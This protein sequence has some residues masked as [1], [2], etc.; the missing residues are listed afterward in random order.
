MGH[1]KKTT[2]KE[3]QDIVRVKENSGNF[4][5]FELRSKNKKKG[6]D[7]KKRKTRIRNV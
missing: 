1:K 3:K 2:A 5:K 6:I 4:N 7:K